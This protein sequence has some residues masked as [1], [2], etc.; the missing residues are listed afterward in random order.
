MMADR[1][2]PQAGA[3]Q[4]ALVK[5]IP[6]AAKASRCGVLAWGL[7]FSVSVQSLRSSMAMNKTFG[8]LSCA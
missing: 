2:G 7:P 3:A 4:W 5:V 8:F 1:E 6:F